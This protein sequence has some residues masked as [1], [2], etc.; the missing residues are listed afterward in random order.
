MRALLAALVAATLLPVSAVSAAPS[1]SLYK[2]EHGTETPEV[3]PD[4]RVVVK[5]DSRASAEEVAERFN[6]RVDADLLPGR[7]LYRI[8]VTIDAKPHEIAKKAGELL[9]RLEKESGIQWAAPTGSRVDEDRFYAW[10]FYAWPTGELERRTDGNDLSAYLDLDT[11]H[12]TATGKGVTVAV[13]DSGFDVDHPMLERQLLDGVDLVDGDDNVGDYMNRV[14]DDGDGLVDEAH[15]HGTFV[16]GIVAQIAPDASILPIRVLDADGVGEIYAVV[17][18]I[19]VAVA[20]GANVINLSFGMR[21]KS[22]AIEQ[23]VKRA[24]KA[25]VVVVAAAGNQGSKDMQYPAADKEVLSVAAYDWTTQRVASFGSRGGWI[26]VSAPGVE[27]VSARPGG[28]RGTW[29]G[30]S[31]AAPIVAGQVALIYELNPTNAAKDARK[32]V[33]DNARKAM[34]GVKDDVGV[35]DFGRTINRFH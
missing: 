1:G 28:G 20:R 6:G 30:S 8:E 31:L 22:K 16:A 23:A 32:A 33:R 14:D 18:G 9:G 25:G 21:Y 10:R 5:T 27:I 35:I 11:A 34:K 7:N 12:L 13:L 17:E 15:G 3:S 19:D 4:V 24:H 29:S 2:H 26:D